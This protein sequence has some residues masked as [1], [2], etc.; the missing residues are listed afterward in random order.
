MQQ[1]RFRAVHIEG[2]P[3]QCR[4]ITGGTYPGEGQQ[5]GQAEDGDSDIHGGANNGQGPTIVLPRCEK[6]LDHRNLCHPTNQGRTIRGSTPS[7]A[8]SISIEHDWPQRQR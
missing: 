1:I 8:C 2:W 4:P 6:R 3:E 5:R 7:S